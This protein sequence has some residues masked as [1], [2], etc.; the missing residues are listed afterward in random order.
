MST[1]ELHVAWCWDCDECGSENFE[2]AVEGDA[3]EA[4]MMIDEGECWSMLVAEEAD[5][6][7][8]DV[9]VNGDQEMFCPT[10]IGALAVSPRFVTCKKC[11]YRFT[12]EVKTIDE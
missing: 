12:T 5:V 10:L 2:R 1:V 3:H 9:E 4:A 11:G 6:T 7:E 8:G